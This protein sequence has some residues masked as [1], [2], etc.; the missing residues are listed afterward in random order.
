MNPL[1][2][3][4]GQ[5]WRPDLTLGWSFAH[6]RGL[7]A[8]AMLGGSPRRDPGQATRGAGVWEPL[9]VRHI[10][11]GAAR[12]AVPSATWGTEAGAGPPGTRGWRQSARRAALGRCGVRARGTLLHDGA[13][14]H[15]S[16]WSLNSRFLG[17]RFSP[18]SRH[19]DI[20]SGRSVFEA[21]GALKER[22]RWETGI[23]LCTLA[24]AGEAGAAVARVFTRKPRH[25]GPHPAWRGGPELGPRWVPEPMGHAPGT[26]QP[27]VQGMCHWG[28]V[29][30]Q[31]FSWFFF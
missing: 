24:L 2:V 18:Q 1:I 13:V 4:P 28:R 31:Q 10:A 30:L 12:G 15:G 3:D 5:R 22:G 21:L 7:P 27:L 19:G 16:P 8:S 20:A 17:A 6:P 23:T 9:P 29:S 14:C 11:S 25:R 26:L